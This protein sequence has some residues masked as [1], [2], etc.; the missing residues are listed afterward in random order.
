[1]R[2][3]GSGRVPSE[4]EIKFSPKS[5]K[6]SFSSSKPRPVRKKPP[7]GKPNWQSSRPQAQKRGPP[8]HDSPPLT[9]LRPIIN[10]DATRR[11]PD[12]RGTAAARLRRTEAI[13]RAQDGQRKPGTDPATNRPGS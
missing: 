9:R 11:N 3:W 5:F 12:H 2:A 4:T 1:M 6:I 13:G 7:T 8:G 10:P